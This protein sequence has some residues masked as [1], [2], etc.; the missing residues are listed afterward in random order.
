VKAFENPGAENPRVKKEDRAIIGPLAM[1]FLFLFRTRKAL[2][3]ACTSEILPLP[4]ET[5]A[6]LNVI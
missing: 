2:H 3:Q 6:V 5:L 1:A 4:I